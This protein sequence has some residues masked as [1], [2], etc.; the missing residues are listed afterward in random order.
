MVLEGI[1]PRVFSSKSR[2]WQLLLFW[3]WCFTEL[4][5]A[6][7]RYLDAVNLG[8]VAALFEVGYCYTHGYG[9]AVDCTKA[10]EYYKGL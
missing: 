10:Y 2:A 6:F 1:Y 8:S 3:N 9:V 7:R 4:E 5:T